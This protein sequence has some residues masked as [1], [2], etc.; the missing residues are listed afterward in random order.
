M[1]QRV[2][3]AIIT[4]LALSGGTA[5]A[6]PPACALLSQAD[7]SAI[8][9]AALQP[10]Q[11][12]PAP[13]MDTCNYASAD[14]DAG[15]SLTV[16]TP[17]SQSTAQIMYNGM[18]QIAPG[19]KLTQNGQTPVPVNGLGDSATYVYSDDDSILWILVGAKIYGLEGN[20]SPNPNLKAA[21][22]AEGRKLIGQ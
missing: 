12:S 10:G 2:C 16:I 19:T 13:Q 15:V 22:L 6:D 8:F 4:V 7:A 1:K 17:G 3:F 18:M 21:L 20:Q 14:T 11:D 9:G 5:W